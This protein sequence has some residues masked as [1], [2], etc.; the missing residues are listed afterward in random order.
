MLS[1]DG[2]SWWRLRLWRRGLARNHGGPNPSRRDSS[3]ASDCFHQRLRVDRLVGTH[4]IFWRRLPCVLLEQR[5]Q[6]QIHPNF[7]DKQH[8]LSNIKFRFVY[9]PSRCL[10]RDGERQFH[11]LE[12]GCV[13]SKELTFS[14]MGM[15]RFHPGSLCFLSWF[16]LTVTSQAA[17]FKNLGFDDADPS[18]SVDFFNS[19]YFVGPA[20]DLLPGWTSHSDFFGSGGDLRYNTFP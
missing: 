18:T 5:D 11:Q 20:K 19:G 17:P 13:R 3:H 7:R 9:D 10:D 14:F 1:A 12:S 8:Q 15:P 16:L 2:E 4:W 6:R